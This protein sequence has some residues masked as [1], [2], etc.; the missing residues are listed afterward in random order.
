MQ[1]GT[2]HEIGGYVFGGYGSDFLASGKWS[3]YEGKL[4]GGKMFER[5]SAAIGRIALVAACLWVVSPAGAAIVSGT[6]KMTPNNSITVTPGVIAFSDPPSA[7]GTGFGTFD[8]IVGS[9]GTFLPFIGQDGTIQD[10]NN[11]TTN[12]P[13]SHTVPV[14]VAVSFADWMVLPIPANNIHFNLEFLF[15]G[16]FSSAGC[17]VLP[18]AAGQ[19]CT[20]SLPGVVSPFNMLN[21]SNDSAQVSF[22][23][24]GTAYDDATPTLI[25]NFVGTF[26]TTFSDKSFQEIL[27]DLATAGF[28]EGS[29]QG[30]F[31]VTFT[32]IPEPS[33]WTL[34]GSGT[35]L[36]ALSRLLRRKRT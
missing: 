18:A 32:P 10:L 23:V 19:T 30:D 1:D 5:F 31:T 11:G 8:I 33:T 12:P 14:G 24:R 17:A 16:I 36:V 3:I 35:A 22:T 29:G 26:S 6:L 4:L 7:D 28:V 9:T 13:N 15:P 34:F 27:N 2:G 25:S 20:P 21:L